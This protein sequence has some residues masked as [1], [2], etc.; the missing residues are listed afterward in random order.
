[1]HYICNTKF[2]LGKSILYTSY[3]ALANFL[4][5]FK[6]E[7]PLLLQLFKSTKIIN[8]EKKITFIPDAF[9]GIQSV[10]AELHDQLQ[11]IRGKHDSG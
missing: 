7:I 10:V 9:A 6:K 11:R 2:I 8:H 4:L 3:P 5:E 1:M